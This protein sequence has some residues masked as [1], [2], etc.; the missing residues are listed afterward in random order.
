MSGEITYTWTDDGAFVPLPRFAAE[1]AQF[2]VGGRY[3]LAAIEE[4]SKRTHDH[5][6]AQVE[7]MWGT[8]PEYLTMRWPSPEHLRKWAL[9]CSGFCHQTEYAMSTPE[10]AARLDRAIRA[11]DEY[12][13]VLVRDSTAIVFTAKTQRLIRN[14][15]EMDRK[16]FQASKQAV[17]D[18][19]GRQL[20]VTRADMRRAD[21]VPAQD[22]DPFPERQDERELASVGRGR[23]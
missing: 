19:I 3:R 2:V 8:L 10:D 6:M 5:F 13:I 14:G 21:L 4:R 7:D 11:Q 20:D 18:V 9:I 22:P 23:G 15:G 17:F 12:A 16:E 1:C